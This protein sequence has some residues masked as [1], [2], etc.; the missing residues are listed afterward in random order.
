MCITWISEYSKNTTSD[1]LHKKI[2]L[3]NYI[4]VFG[5]SKVFLTKIFLSNINIFSK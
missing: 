2:F 1:V 3:K 4:N 5:I